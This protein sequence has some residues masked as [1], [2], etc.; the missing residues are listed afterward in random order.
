[1]KRLQLA[2]SASALSLAL[3]ALPAV[4]APTT[5]SCQPDHTYVYFSY[6]H[7][8]FSIQQH[9]FDKVTGTVTYDPE[10]KSGSVDV[11]IDTKSI[12]TV[13]SVL[14]GHLQAAEF[15]DTAEYPTITFHSTKVNFHGDEPTSVEGELTV[16]G[17]TKPV[18]FKLTHFHQG[19]N[20]G[21]KNALGANATGTV[22]RS[23]F[24]MGK[25][26]P[27]IGDEVT[28]SIVFEGWAS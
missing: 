10:A 8:G 23:D 19:L 22:K 1:M 12:N 25:Y 21:K 15:F 24:N 16:K 18:T 11:T 14:N 27:L 6:L 13:S 4:A 26:V 20:L 2:L 28:I 9:R 3:V 7:Q 5:Y 17:V